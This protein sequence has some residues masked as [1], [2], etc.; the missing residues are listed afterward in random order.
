LSQ[1]RRHGNQRRSGDRHRFG[2]YRRGTRPEETP[3]L[4]ALLA[5][6]PSNEMI[7]WPVSPRV[8]NIKNNDPSLIEAIA[9][10]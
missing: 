5:L 2:A 4:K 1:S 9:V 6:Y 7:C 3:Q 10:A 8:G